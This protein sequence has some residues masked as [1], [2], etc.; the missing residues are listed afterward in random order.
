MDKIATIILLREISKR[1]YRFRAY[2]KHDTFFSA[3]CDIDEQALVDLDQAMYTLLDIYD[4]DAIMR[5]LNTLEESDY[6]SN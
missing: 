5:I 3:M 2:G 4:E 6:A 1:L